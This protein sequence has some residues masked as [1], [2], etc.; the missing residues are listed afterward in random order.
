MQM[1]SQTPRIK[2]SQ[3][4]SPILMATASGTAKKANSLLGQ[5]MD[6]HLSQQRVLIEDSPPMDHETSLLQ[7]DDWNIDFGNEPGINNAMLRPEE[8]NNGMHDDAEIFA[9]LK[10]PYPELAEAQAAVM[11]HRSMTF[12][13]PKTLGHHDFD[14]LLDDKNP[15][16]DLSIG[17]RQPRLSFDFNEG[18]HHGF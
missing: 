6:A 8:L 15:N 3:R 4:R 14:G 7:Q 10:E 18:N 11:R 16:D 5:E 1:L 2:A 17:N 12:N 13:V 9:D